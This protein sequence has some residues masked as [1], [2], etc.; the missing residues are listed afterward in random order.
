M[1]GTRGGLSLVLKFPVNEEPVST[2]VYSTF[3]EMGFRLMVHNSIEFP[4]EETIGRLTPVNREYYISVRPTQTVCSDQVRQLTIEDRQCVFSEEHP[5]PFFHEYSELNCEFECRMSKI[6]K[7][8]GCMPFNFFTEKNVAVCNFTKIPCIVKNWGKYFPG[9][10][11]Y[12][13]NIVFTEEV[14]LVRSNVSEKNPRCDCLSN[15]QSVRYDVQ[16]NYSFLN[17]ML[18]KNVVDNF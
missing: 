14:M 12:T 7:L 3:M 15:C 2:S 5:S 18:L 17:R 11:N 9:A 13:C 16:P 1:H 8:C 10:I 4:N 6:L